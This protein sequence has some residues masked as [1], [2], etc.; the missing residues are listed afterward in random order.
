LVALVFFVAF[1]MEGATN[2]AERA[3]TIRPATAADAEKIAALWQHM[4]DQHRQMDP[5]FWCW[6]EG[7]AEAF[8]K[9]T[10]GAVGKEN[11]VVL[12][13]ETP[14]G[15]VVGFVAAEVK[16][17]PPVY[18]KRRTG[19]VGDLVVH[20]A[21][22]RRR[23]AEALMREA[24]ERMRALGATSVTLHAALANPAAIRLYERLGMRPVM[25]RMF[26]EL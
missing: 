1:V 7:A 16:D 20:P 17:R 19:F 25:Y 10:A 3:Y 5:A 9:Y 26:R 11:W 12:V 4:A 21:Y 14:S 13:A 23:I 15:E 22:R 6:A 24:F 18:P 2:M 8:R